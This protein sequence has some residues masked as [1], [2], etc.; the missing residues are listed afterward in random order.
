MEWDVSCSDMRCA[1]EPTYS[2]VRLVFFVS[3]LWNANYCRTRGAVEVEVDV[4][5]Q[6]YFLERRNEQTNVKASFQV[7]VHLYKT[8]SQPR[9]DF[10][11]YVTTVRMQKWY[12]KEG[13]QKMNGTARLLFIFLERVRVV[14]GSYILSVWWFWFMLNPGATN[15]PKP[16]S[17][18][19]MPAAKM[20]CSGT[21]SEDGTKLN[22]S[23][24]FVDS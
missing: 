10:G 15:M 20:S 23:N 13:K 3:D 24:G 11:K 1:T 5:H 21:E 7:R 9:M 16:W 22:V 14:W 19:P 12:R 2:L 4:H 8:T 6:F 18:K 17:V